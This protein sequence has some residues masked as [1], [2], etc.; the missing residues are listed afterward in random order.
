MIKSMKE[1]IIK[2]PDTS[3]LTKR[4]INKWVV[5]SSDYKRLLASGNTL[6]DVLKK[7]TTEK[8]KVVFR[9]SPNLGYAPSSFFGV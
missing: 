7:T 8:R 5:L 4:H 1:D 6:S 2:V 9:V 3:S